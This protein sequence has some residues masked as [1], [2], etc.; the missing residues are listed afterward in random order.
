MCPVNQPAEIIP[1]IHTP[2]LDTVSESHRHTF[3]NVYVVSN[4][5]RFP[6]ADIENKVEATPDTAYFLASLT[7]TFASTILMQLIEP[8]EL[9]LEDP[10]SKYGVRIKSPE[11]IRIKHLFSHTSEGIPGSYYK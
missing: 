9:E 4:E 8:G 3:C 1:L 7:K 11:K 2:E 5:E 6:I 10:V